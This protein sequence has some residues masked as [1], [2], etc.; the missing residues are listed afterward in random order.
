MS[1][2]SGDKHTTTTLFSDSGAS[3]TDGVAV[4]NMRAAEGQNDWRSAESKLR[5]RSSR[6]G[7]ICEVSSTS[8]SE[9]NIREF[10]PSISRQ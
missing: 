7:A 5:R 10:S 1:F 8:A 9:Q 6:E 4:E 3:V 2:Q